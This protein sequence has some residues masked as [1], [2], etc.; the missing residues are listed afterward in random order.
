[1]PSL[2]HALTL[3]LCAYRRRLSAWFAHRHL[4]RSQTPPPPRASSFMIKITL[5]PPLSS[6]LSLSLSLSISPPKR[7]QDP[8]FILVALLHSDAR[9]GSQ[10]ADR[11]STVCGSRGSR[12]MDKRGFK[13]K[14]LV[15]TRGREKEGSRV[16]K[17]GCWVRGAEKGGAS[18]SRCGFFSALVH[19]RVF[20][21]GR[22]RERAKGLFFAPPRRGAAR[23]WARRAWVIRGAQKI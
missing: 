22:R 6:H 13:K 19:Q 20:A 18:G 2:S 3:F 10:M 5:V 17:V 12:V 11:E 15:A 7:L 4:G 9:Q 14:E 23:R 21:S 1:L 8:P 16:E